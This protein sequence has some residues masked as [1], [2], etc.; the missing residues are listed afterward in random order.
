MELRGARK[1]GAPPERVDPPF[2]DED[3]EARRESGEEARGD[4]A[5]VPRAR[6][7]GEAHVPRARRD[8]VLLVGGEADG[9]WR[10]H[11]D[12]PEIAKSPDDGASR[13]GG[14]E[15]TVVRAERDNL[16]SVVLVDAVAE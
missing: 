6:D 11:G 15:E 5:P 3:A 13:V 12:P 9:A 10:E 8:D 7:R 1:P 16:P 2:A 14:K 4:D